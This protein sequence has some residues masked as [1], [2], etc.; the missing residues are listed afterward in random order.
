M[1]YLRDCTRV[2]VV[3][4][5][6]SRFLYLRNMTFNYDLDFRVVQLKDLLYT[7]SLKL[8]VF[9]KYSQNWTRGSADVEQN[10]NSSHVTFDLCL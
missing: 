1:T 9:M 8:C 7:F 6:E 4:L 10:T 2:S 3:I 5:L